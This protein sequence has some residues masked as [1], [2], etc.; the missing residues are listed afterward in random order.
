VKSPTRSPRTFATLLQMSSAL[1]FVS[2]CPDEAIEEARALRR[3]LEAAGGR[4]FLGA[5][6]VGR[7]AQKIGEMIGGAPLVIILGTRKYAERKTSVSGSYQELRLAVEGRKPVF[8]IKMCEEFEELYAQR[9]LPLP[10][11]TWL[12]DIKSPAQ[13]PNGLVHQIQARLASLSG[14]RWKC[15]KRHW[16]LALA[17]GRWRRLGSRSTWISARNWPG[18]S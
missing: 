16:Q 2:L 10:N 18:S 15:W 5:E 12:P 8:L 6:E 14:L 11:F 4:C 3:A 7:N 1:L 13:V 17:P 9:H